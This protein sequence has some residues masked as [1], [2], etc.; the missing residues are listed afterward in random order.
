MTNSFLAANWKLH[1]DMTWADKITQ[2][3]QI[4]PVSKR[5]NIDICICPPF[6]FIAA[7]SAAAKGVNIYTGAQA[8]DPRSSGAHTGQ[9][10]A[11]MV[12]SAG[13]S[14]VIAGHSER[15]AMGECNTDVKSQAEAILTAGLTPILC[16]GESL[17]TR[18]EGEADNFVSEQLK[19][20]WPEPDKGTEVIIA[21]EPIWAIGTGKVPSSGDIA[22]MHK[23][24]RDI[25]GPN[26]RILY[27]G[28]VKPANAK[29]ILALK[30][31]NGALVGGASL[32][33]ESFA[34]IASAA[35]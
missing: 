22:A 8:S 20:C 15:R 31:V 30:N 3:D 16:V 7:L 17:E 32:D 9:V 4:I 11:A 25:T 33:M 34:A 19:A 24:I 5:G 2:F 13:A 10:N 26:H 28:S 35:P 23:T 18:E 21:Y 1:G 6:P 29:E 12:K 14:Y 27:G